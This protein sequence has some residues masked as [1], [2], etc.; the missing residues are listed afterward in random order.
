MVVKSKMEFVKCNG[1]IK[2]DGTAWCR[3]SL[4][5]DELTVWQIFAP[6]SKA[7][8]ILK[9]CDQLQAHKVVTVSLSLVPAFDGSYRV[10]LQGIEA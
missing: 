5:D 8:E 10:S 9:V 4:I 3:V 6:R 1:S 7:L 2:E